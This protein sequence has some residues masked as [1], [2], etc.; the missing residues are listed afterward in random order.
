MADQVRVRYAPSPT[1]MQHIGGVRTALFNYLFARAN[2]GSFVLRIEDTDRTRFDPAAVEDIYATFAWLGIDPDE[3][4]REGGEF[5]PYV[6]S[7][8]LDRYRAAAADLVARGVAYEDFTSAPGA[9]EGDGADGERTPYDGAGR[10][11][12]DAER[13]ARRAAGE[14]PVVRLLVPETG[15]TILH[16][17]VLG[18]IRKKNKDIPTDP[19]LLKSD[20][21]PTYH[22]ANVVDDHAM[23]ITHVLR[24]QEWV[25]SAPIHLLLYDAFGWAPPQFAHLP[26]VMGKDGSK[27]SKRHGATSAIEFRRQGYLAEAVLNYIALLGWS[28]DD[29]REFFTLRELE[30]LFTVERINRAPA[31]FDY[32]KLEWFNGSYIRDLDDDA[33]GQLLAP[34]LAAEGWLPARRGAPTAAERAHAPAALPPNAARDAS[35]GQSDPDATLAAIVPL[36]R[37]RLRRLSDVTELVRFLFV[38]V[39]EWDAAALTPKKATAADAL[40]WLDAATGVLDAVGAVSEQAFTDAMRARA[41]SLGTGLGNLLMPLRVA[42][43]GSSVSPPLTGSIAALGIEEARARIAGARATLAAVLEQN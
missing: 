42:I 10:H 17:L 28:Y 30:E 37:E 9:H 24:A 3:G 32:R 41:E 29:S 8:R 36:V 43:T 6:Q 22:L 21:F 12:S 7:E 38:P 15:E 18:R 4:P 5:A 26:M 16:D 13:D 14:T 11:T 33:L 34:Y 1:G 23:G 19:I 40:Q 25:P 2:G 35:G 39:R 27:L 31:V 20:G